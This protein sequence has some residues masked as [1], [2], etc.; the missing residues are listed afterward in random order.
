M[1]RTWIALALAAALC[2]GGDSAKGEPL[3]AD[4]VQAEPASISVPL[5]A[6]A[7]DPS[8]LERFL[9]FTIDE[10]TGEWSAG[11]DAFE[12]VLS[13]AGRGGVSEVCVMQLKWMG[14]ARTGLIQPVLELY[15]FGVRE[16][17]ANA[18]SIRVGNLRYDV[19]VK[20]EEVKVGGRSAERMCA[21]LTESGMALL[22]AF[23]GA[24][25]YSLRLHGGKRTRSTDVKRNY[26]G[27][28]ERGKLMSASFECFSMAGEVDMTDYHLW[29][30]NA[31]AWKAAHG[32]EPRM[33][34]VALSQEKGFEMLSIGDSGENVKVL[35]KQ[36]IEHWFLSGNTDTAYDE[37]LRDA[38]LRAQK[39]YGL[40][41]TGSADSQLMDYL[42]GINAPPVIEP[43]AESEMTQLG[44]V[45]LRVD[46]YWFA[47]TIQSSAP[48][49]NGYQRHAASN[50]DNVLVVFEGEIRNGDISTLNLDW[51]LKGTVNLDGYPYGCVFLCERDH[52]SAFDTQLLPQAV[53]R[54]IV[55]AEIPHAALN[56]RDVTLAIEQDGQALLFS[57]AAP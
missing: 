22:N 38:V 37:R 46:R 41:Q 50:L 27:S 12:A 13:N 17:K 53:S 35:Q 7:F 25:A 18:I 1:H 3:Q 42:A 28:D 4:Q 48:T 10:E 40:M 19:Q 15:Y 5:A 47:H 32:F 52:G 54:L 56:A 8:R 20:C 30:L 21:P 23:S 57:G 2:F 45:S 26:S 33:D 6:Q 36:L 24:D 16:V 31:T 29:D 39:H 44:G 9:S 14:N 51:Q 55:A 49:P 43:I 34:A 11:A